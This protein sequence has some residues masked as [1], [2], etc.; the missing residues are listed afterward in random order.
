MATP[1]VMSERIALP[2]AATAQAKRRRRIAWGPVIRHIVLGFFAVVILFPIFWVLLLSIKSVPDANQNEIWPRVFDFSHYEFVLRRVSTLPQN[3]ANS[4]MVTFG[5]VAIAT[6]CAVFAGY[7]LVFLD[8]PGKAIVTAVLVA[9]MFFPTRITA[10][11]AI[12]ETQKDLGLLNV[13]A[14]LIFPY[15]S[16]SVALSVFIMRGIFQTVSREIYDAARID[17]AGPLR[18]L[19]QILLPL[20]TNGIIVVIIINFGAAWGEYLLS[21][22]LN[23]RPLAQTL[24]VVLAT[25]L[26]GRGGWSWPKAAAV[27]VLTITPGLLAFAVAQRWYMKGLQEGA[28]KA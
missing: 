13:P 11:I 20:V 10:I 27:Y 4:V 3:Y 6:V 1:R 7:A 22:T 19:L 23:T 16:L 12:Y 15:V 9:S 26:G 8:V 25:G 5:T 18:M 2:A 28:L 21:K 17:G 14:G 24:P